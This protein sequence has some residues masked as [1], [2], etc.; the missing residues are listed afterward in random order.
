MLGRV[1]AGQR[2]WCILGG[3]GAYRRVETPTILARKHAIFEAT[4][5]VDCGLYAPPEGGVGS[6]TGLAVLGFPPFQRLQSGRAGGPYPTLKPRM[7]GN[8]VGTGQG[9][10]SGQGSN[11]GLGTAKG[12]RTRDGRDVGSAERTEA[13]HPMRDREV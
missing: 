13:K 6:Q 8:G 1:C 10:G 4:Q 2:V 5:H 11:E 3:G 12:C 7:A 9:Q